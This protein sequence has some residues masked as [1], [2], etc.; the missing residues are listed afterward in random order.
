MRSETYSLCD[1]IIVFEFKYRY[2]LLP[3]DPTPAHT[4]RDDLFFDFIFSRAIITRG[5]SSSLFLFSPTRHAI[6][7]TRTSS[8]DKSVQLREISVTGY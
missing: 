7:I 3:A 5:R 2:S 6:N 8:D 4:S 1:D